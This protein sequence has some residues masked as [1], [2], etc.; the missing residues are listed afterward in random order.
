MESLY[1]I[2]GA[3]LTA[4]ELRLLTHVA[5]D[6]CGVWEPD[7]EEATNVR[8]QLDHLVLEGFLERDKDHAGWLNVWRVP[9]NMWTILEPNIET[10]HC[11][12]DSIAEA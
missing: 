2:E 3:K 12:V 10:I 9:E 8:E 4:L 5:G 1:N 7:E 6:E 11:V